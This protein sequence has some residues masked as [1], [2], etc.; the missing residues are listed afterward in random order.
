[1]NDA[2]FQ[3]AVV[4][5]PGLI[6][7]TIADT[8]IAGTKERSSASM[9]LRAFGFGLVAYSIWFLVYG[10]FTQL[11]SG[12]WPNLFDKVR[13]APGL[14]E[15]RLLRP[16]D[17]FS[18]SILSMGLAIIWSVA[19]NR[20]WFLRAMQRCRVTQK[21]GDE[22]VWEYTLNLG[23]PAVEYANIRDFDNH[24]LYS[25]YIRAF[26]EGTGTRELL[27]D[28]AIVYD[29]DTA[30]KLFETPLLYLARKPDSLHVEYPDRSGE[31]DT[32][33]QEK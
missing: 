14:Q 29:L 31:K 12:A 25:G 7:L 10:I 19:A 23:I 11:R 26:S 9:A 20:K 16:L 32:K 33:K 8:L 3:L 21:Y 22:S 28:D 15:L 5:L 4:F 30:Q 13:T 2:L 18:A 27:L 1:M 17:I 6:W 24:I